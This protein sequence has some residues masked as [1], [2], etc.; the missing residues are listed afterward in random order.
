MTSLDSLRP[1]FRAV[2]AV[3][4]AVSALLTA[5]FGATLATSWPMAALLAVGLMGATFA[6]A[7]IWPVVVELW[8]NRSFGSALVM[9]LFAA[10][11]TTTDLTTNFGS[12]A[13]QRAANVDTAKVQAAVYGDRRDQVDDH[14]ASIELWTKHLAALE[15]EHGWLPTVTAEA[16]RAQLA[17]AEKAIELESA[18][19]GCKARCLALMKE[20]DTLKSRIALAEKRADIA[21]QLAETKALIAKARDKAAATEHPQSAVMMQTASI[22]SVLTRSLRPS[23]EAQHW[24]DTGV[25]WLVAAFFALGAIG[26]NLVGYGQPQAPKMPREKQPSA[27]VR[28]MTFREAMAA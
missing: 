10:L 9:T 4:A 5:A 28:R 27:P 16:M 24:T 12:V 22:A 6:S 18:R 21:K 3:L 19:G 17:S 14:R 1:R 25:S 23:A 11:F 26:C 7:Y 8:R 20:R 13:W 15:A 2:G